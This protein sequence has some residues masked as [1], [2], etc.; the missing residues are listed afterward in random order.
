MSSASPASTISR[1]AS[2]RMFT[3]IFSGLL[4]VL[5]R[6]SL[7]PWA[8]LTPD[9]MRGPPSPG[10][11]SP[12][13][14]VPPAVFANAEYDSH[15]DRGIPL[16]ADFAS[17]CPSSWLKHLPSRIISSSMILNLYHIF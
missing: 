9:N 4:R 16:L 7:M 1:S 17:K 3:L 11:S 5:Q 10:S 6:S 15:R 13:T 2:V 8:F 12:M 14:I